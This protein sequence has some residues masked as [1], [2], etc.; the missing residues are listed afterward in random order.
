MALAHA[1]E[2]RQ[3]VHFACKLLSF[4]CAVNEVDTCAHLLQILVEILFIIINLLIIINLFIYNNKPSQA[5]SKGFKPKGTIFPCG[6]EINADLDE[7]M[8][9]R[10]RNLAKMMSKLDR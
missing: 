4:L 1:A 10:L 6:Y 3:D 9:E 7:T 5:F 8:A 2:H